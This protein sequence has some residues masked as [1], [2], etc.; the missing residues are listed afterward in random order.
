MA[1]KDALPDKL[2]KIEAASLNEDEMALVIKG[3]KTALKGRKKYPNKS[4]SRGK[5]TCFKCGKS[6]HFIA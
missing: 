5:R 4:K 3:F 6:G 2:A 1:N